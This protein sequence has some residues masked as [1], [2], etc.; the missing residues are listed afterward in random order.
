MAAQ[1]RLSSEKSPY[2]LQHKDNP[3][4]WYAWGE[5][6]FEKATAEDKPVFLSIGYSACY[7]C[8]VMEKDSFEQEDVA[9]ILND[10]FVSVKVDRE[11]RPDIDKVYMDAVVALT[12]RGGWPLSAIL[13]PSREVFWGGTFFFREQFKTILREIQSIWHSDRE[14]V[15]QSADA[16]RVFLLQR[17][18]PAPLDRQ[19]REIVQRAYSRL[20][21]S[22]DSRN[23]GFGGPPKFP[24]AQ[25]IAFLL[26]YAEGCAPEERERAHV[27]SFETLQRM[28]Q[29]GIYDHLGG[30]FHRYS[31]DGA[32]LIPHFE[33]MLYDNALLVSVYLD[34]F[35]VHGLD[36]FRRTAV[37]TMEFCLREFRTPEGGFCSAQDAGDV[38]EEGEYY[39]WKMSDIRALLSEREISVFSSIYSFT[40][41]GNFEKGMNVL[42]RQREPASAEESDTVRECLG[43]LF[44]YRIS[45]RTPPR[46]DDKVLAGWN[47]L[48]IST[49]CRAYRVLGGEKYIE[50]ARSCMR[51]IMDRLIVD[52]R[53]KRRY[54]DGDVRFNGSLEDHAF[55]IQALLDLYECDFD[56][57]WLS[58]A[59]KLQQEQDERFMDEKDGCYFMSDAPDVPVR[60][61]DF[62]DGATP[63][64]NS[65]A[66]F[67]L[68]RLGELFP[69]KK[70]H[71]NAE[72]LLCG[73]GDDLLRHP[74]AFCSAVQAVLF[75]S[76][77]P[78]VV[79][80]AGNRKD[81]AFIEMQKAAYAG[82]KAA[83]IIASAGNGM[84]PVAM[85]KRAPEGKVMAYICRGQTCSEPISE[86]G[87]LRER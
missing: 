32:W 9:K 15:M 64:G 14:R 58:T 71:L 33:K 7:W 60:K 1:N 35:Q 43:K 81:A 49:L 80:L 48:M 68:Y 28:A 57:G 83:R 85:G 30:G 47:G 61:K 62:F 77:V 17:Q 22:Y 25:Q 12:G 27:M 19:K 10:Y 11:E 76:A 41:Q 6:A 55:V 52:G 3:V 79:V 78:E 39:V 8:H 40:D 2:L 51:F 53:L 16:L 23:A 46:I 66:L 36:L 70:F 29:G 20:S 87:V 18:E 56:E 67:N 5:D 34:A 37:E 42:A 69:D 72:A 84:V 13:T 44:D 54:R 74:V 24:P 86:P 31:V 50:S 38:G 59:L 75:D 73:F 82:L 63:S 26:R 4:D 45:H 21:D 65:V